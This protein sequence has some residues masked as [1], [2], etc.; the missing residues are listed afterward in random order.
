MAKLKANAKA[1][2]AKNPLLLGRSIGQQE[3]AFR[4]IQGQ[5]NGTALQPNPR[6]DKLQKPLSADPNSEAL[7]QQ[8]YAKLAADE[9]EKE[10]VRQRSLN[11]GQMPGRRPAD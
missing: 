9:G 5:D 3:P 10:I 8:G 11:R 6:L 2:L 7:L 1:A 4:V